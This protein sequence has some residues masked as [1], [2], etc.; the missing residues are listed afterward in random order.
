VSSDLGATRTASRIGSRLL[1]SLHHRLELFGIELT[2]EKERLLVALV[3]AIVAATSIFVGF[4]SLNALLAFL[5]WEQRVPL[6][7][8]L[9]LLYLGGGILLALVTKSRVVN[10][11]AP[12]AAT[13][14]ELQRDAKTFRSEV[15]HD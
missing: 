7:A 11:P 3:G 14:E 1:D 10:G 13:M 12:F 9:T 15:S 8:G 2:E 4:L 5:F 6:F